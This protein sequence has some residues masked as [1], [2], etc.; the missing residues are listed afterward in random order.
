MVEYTKVV[1]VNGTE[2]LRTTIPKGVTRQLGIRSDMALEW[3]ITVKDS[4][5]APEVTKIEQEREIKR[6]A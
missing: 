1:V 5:I 3:Q 2:S 6:D 4:K